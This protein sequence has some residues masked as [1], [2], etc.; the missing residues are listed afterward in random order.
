[1]YLSLKPGNPAQWSGVLFVRKGEHL[2]YGRAF[3]LTIVRTGPYAPAILRFRVSFPLNYPQSPPVIAF[4]SDIFHPLVTPLTTY[5][6]SLGIPSSDIVSARDEERLPPGGFSLKH[7]F[8]TWF[9]LAKQNAT[10]AGS[11]SGSY[12]TPSSQHKIT[13]EALSSTVSVSSAPLQVPLPPTW[14]IPGRSGIAEVLTYVKKAFDDETTLDNLPFEYAGNPGAWNAWRAHRRKALE[15][16]E[17]RAPRPADSQRLRDSD[18]GQG[19]DVQSKS[20]RQPDEWNWDGVWQERVQ[21][22][23][24]ASISDPVLYGSNGSDEPVGFDNTL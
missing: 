1:M 9:H 14:L 12:Q 17:S 10:L 7:Y 18:K 8:P 3:R 6:H 4:I 13:A 21:K 16:E 15:K 2:G 24:D 5:T 11:S 20:I 22:G 19:G 23:I